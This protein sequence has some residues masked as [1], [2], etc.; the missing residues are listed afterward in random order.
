VNHATDPA[1]FAA[2][3][4]RGERAAVARCISALER[5]DPDMQALLQGLQPLPAQAYRI[6]LTG[7]PGAG[8]STLTLQLVRALRAAGGKVGVLAV[9][10]SS[11]FSGG[12]LLGDRVRMNDVAGDEGVF[13]RSLATRGAL[14]GLSA[15]VADAADVLDAAGFEHVLVETVGVGQSECDIVRLCDT[16]VVVLTP[17]S[18]DEIQVAKAGLM[19]IADLFVINK[20]DRPGGERLRAALRSMLDQARARRPDRDW[21]TPI[22]KTTADSGAGIADLAAALRQH[23][24]HL[25]QH[26]ELAVRRRERRRQQVVQLAAGLLEQRLWSPARRALLGQSLE[27]AGGEAALA[28]AQRLVDDFLSDRSGS[29]T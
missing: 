7:P 6:G 19:E 2:A 28:I 8:K 25:Q 16:T 11:P 23:R 3:V 9:D 24:L 26:G 12:A 13:I 14:G 15:A 1:G 18:G 20:D 10:P 21:D 4:R 29:S 5:R 17:E 27:A 22:L